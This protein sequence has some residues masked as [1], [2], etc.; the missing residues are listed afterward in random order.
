MHNCPL[1]AYPAI[2]V[3]LL[4]CIYPSACL[5]LN[6]VPTCSGVLPW[7]CPPSLAPASFFRTT[8]HLPV[9]PTPLLRSG[10]T[11]KSL[12]WFFIV[13]A[14]LLLFIAAGLVSSGVVFFTSAGMFGP[15]FPYEV[16][17][18]VGKC[19]DVGASLGSQSLRNAA[20]R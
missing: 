4:P 5:V 1:S 7:G 14:G 6:P 9:A 2:T 12:K 11:I 18:W 10:R 16:R 13:S 20:T 17:A 19:V 3:R 8:S 15:T